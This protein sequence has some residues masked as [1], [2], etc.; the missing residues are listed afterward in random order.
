MN[1]YLQILCLLFLSINIYAQSISDDFEGNGNI[2]TWAADACNLNTNLSNPY[3]TGIN[4]SATVLEYHDIGG[5]YA[6]IR[7]DKGSNFDLSTYATFSLKVYV[8]SSGITG[9]QTNQIS[10]KLQDG[11]LG[12]PWT[13]QSEVIKT[14][15]LDQWQTITFDFLNDT[16]V[17]FDVN[18]AP[19][20][21]RTDFNRVILQVNG[22]NNNDNVLAYIDDVLYDYTTPAAS[23]FNVLVW[24]DEFDVD[25]AINSTNWHHQTQLPAGGNWYNGESQHYTDRID[26]SFVS[27]GVLNIVAKK[28]VFTDQ[29]YTKQ[30]TSARLN[31]KYAFKYGRVEIRAKLPTGIGTWPA[32]WMLGKNIN[33]D[34]GYWDNQGYGTTSWPACG[35]MDIME[36]WGTNQ[37]YVTSA[38]HTPSSFGNTV[39]HGGQSISTA[40][41]GFHVYSLEWTS[42]KLVFAVDG[43]INFTYNPSV[44]DASTWPFDAEQYFLF[45]IAMESSVDPSFTQSTMEVDY[46]RVYQDAAPV[47]VTA[48][49]I[50][51]HDEI[52]DDVISIFS[53]SYSNV[54]GTN[55]NPY[56]NQ[57]TVTTIESIDGNSTLKYDGLNYQGT[58]YTAQNVT[59]QSYLHLDF[60]TADATSLDFYLISQN[61]T[62]DSDFYS[63]S[64]ANKEQWVSVDIPLSSFPNVDLTK[65]SQFKIVGNGTV[66]FDNLY[67]HDGSIVPVELVNFEAI[68]ESNANLLTW[69]TASELNNSHFEIERSS[70]G[71][72]FEKIGEIV[73][74]GTS[75]ELNN[76]FFKDESP[77]KNS[78]Y[79]LR[80]VDYDN[81]FYYSKILNI[82][83]KTLN[84]SVKIYPIPAT[85]NLT[86]SFDALEKETININVIDIMGKSVK[87]KFI[88]I[89]AGNNI[90]N[91]NFSDLISG[92]YFISIQTKSDVINRS[93]IKN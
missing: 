49:P 44:K 6:N 86:I 72:N 61:P 54:A 46:I 41:T 56:W 19:P 81:T 63:L 87:Q 38:T 11:T 51:I 77:L 78:Y 7:F 90:I 82:K 34:G 43:V 62:V 30:Y 20:T 58:E 50:P 47:T 69:E 66:Y 37:N 26:N 17:N 55:Y 73:G 16:Y 4:T 80:Q 74:N 88:P 60:W 93:I 52:A 22:E 48:A 27:G 5:Q 59:A 67:F 2:T 70:D 28:E 12:S 10:L 8:P 84:H 89:E 24:S 45:N 75:L 32:L 64:T 53:D 35:E 85:D 91:L 83:R 36:H 15:S 79:R 31:S 39:N 3:Q 68:E 65:V 21:Q 29:G 76:Y 42:D 25:G 9:N 23:N 40:S 71:L 1:R 57:S 18:S 33:E 13:T 92:N 14:V